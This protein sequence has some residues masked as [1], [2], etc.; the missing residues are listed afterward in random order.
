MEFDIP[1]K[2]WTG[3]DVVY[4]HLKVFGCKAFA[5]IPKEQRSKLDDKAFPC[6]L[7]GYGN[8]EFGYRLWDP[9]KK[10]IFRSRDVIFYE[11]Q[12]I[13]YCEKTEKVKAISDGVY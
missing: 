5:H 9:V 11:D 6:I 13:S 12:T 1:E 4:N 2:V 10:K 3:K 7:V 8:E